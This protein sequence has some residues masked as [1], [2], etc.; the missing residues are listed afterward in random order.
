[1][2]WVSTPYRE[3]RRLGSKT[4]VPSMQRD[5]SSA[6]RTLFTP[7]RTRQTATRDFLGY[8]TAVTPSGATSYYYPSR[9]IPN[10]HPDYTTNPTLRST[11][12][13]ESCSPICSPMRSDTRGSSP[14][15]TNQRG[16][17]SMSRPPL[18][19]LWGSLLCRRFRE[20]RYRTS[21]SRRP[22]V[23]AY[24]ST[25]YVVLTDEQLFD[26][27]VA[28]GGNVIVVGTNPTTGN[29]II[30]ESC[31]LRYVWGKVVSAPKYQ[32]LPATD[33]LCWAVNNAPITTTAVI[34]LCEGDLL[35]KWYNVPQALYDRQ[36]ME[37]VIGKT[38]D[39]DFGHALSPIGLYPKGTLV[40]V[41]PDIEPFRRATGEI[42][43]DITY[44]FKYYPKGANKFYY[45]GAKTDM[46]LGLNGGL[47]TNHGPDF[48]FATRPYQGKA[49]PENRLSTLPAGV[50]VHLFPYGDYSNLFRAQVDQTDTT[51]L[52][53]G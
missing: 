19:R 24:N 42:Y 39:V 28:G 1:M 17:T 3:D 6:Q 32:T 40:F 7:W 18:H 30:D 47:E 11:P 23:T 52:D 13:S 21:S 9:Q 20:V 16:R 8:T 22:T 14:T 37:S 45:V 12:Y 10:Y 27:G 50:N 2:G 43:Y 31:C 5:S 26:L 15:F 35:L 51:L 25:P 48:Y 34:I 49:V 44:R 4:P 36:L 41:S 46:S 53:N 38:N 29:E 33:T